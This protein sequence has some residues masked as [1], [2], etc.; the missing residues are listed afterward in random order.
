MK[1]HSCFLLTLVAACGITATAAAKTS[2]PA[3]NYTIAGNFTTTGYSGTY[4]DTHAVVGDVTTDTLV[5][6]ATASSTTAAATST[7]TTTTT[8]NTDGSKVVVFS[9]L[10]FGATVASTF[11]IDLAAPV[12]HSAAGTGTFTLSSGTTGTLTALRFSLGGEE[13]TSLDLTS[14]AGVVTE[15]VLLSGTSGCAA[16]EL[17]SVSAANALTVTSIKLSAGSHHH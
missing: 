2:G 3:A 16:D 8:T 12:S 5:L 7:I 11:T 6:T 15:E 13:V 4:V 17:L 9:D 1:T 10:D 14:A